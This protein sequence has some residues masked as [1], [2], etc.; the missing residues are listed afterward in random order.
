MAEY[1]EGTPEAPVLR[2]Q[3]SFAIDHWRYRNNL[4]KKVREMLAGENPISAPKSAQYKV[5]VMHTFHMLAI[6]NE[7]MSRFLERPRI[8]CVSSGVSQRSRDHAT[9][10]ENWINEAWTQADMNAGTSVWNAVLR[11]ALAFDLGVERIEAA[12]AAFWPELAIKVNEDGE[13]Y[14]ELSR[15]FEDP[16]VFETEKDKYLRHCGLPIR[17]VYVPVDTY[18]PLYN[19]PTPEQEF[20]V[21]YRPLR[22]VLT[23]KMFSAE[24]KARLGE[25]GSG[26]HGLTTQVCILHVVNATTHSYF[27]LIPSRNWSGN[28]W[29]KANTPDLNQLGEP[30]LLHS[31]ETGVNRSIYNTVAGRFGGW[32]SSQDWI[33]GAW[34]EAMCALN[35][36]A[37][38]LLSQAATYLRNTS[39]PTMVTYFDPE[40]RTTDGGPPKPMTVQEGQGIAL[41]KGENM[42]ILFKPQGN[43]MFESVYDKTFQRMS[44][45]A[46]SA[47][48]MGGKLPG[49]DTGYHHELQISQSEHL[50]AKIEENFAT[51]AVNDAMLFLSHV[52]AIGEKVY[53]KPMKKDARGRYYGDAISLSA[54]DLDPM[55][56]LVAKV[57]GVSPLSTVANLRA[58]LEAT[59]P[60]P[61]GLGPL[62]DDQTA[63]E[64]FLGEEAP[65]EILAKRDIQRERN[66]LIQ[67]GVLSKMIGQKLNMMMVE[68]GVPSVSPEMAAGADP[69]LLQS[70]QGMNADGT[71]EQ[72]GGVDPRLLS[73]QLEGRDMAGMPPATEQVVTPRNGLGGGV[74]AGQPQPEQILGKRIASMMR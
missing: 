59:A 10:Q 38:E 15:K 53:V 57:R 31:Y 60:R 58:V 8:A 35:Q 70:L 55:P 24:A 61:E 56:T 9:K 43:P 22:A 68:D 41:W 16:D 40:Y 63:M 34:I 14:S 45:L 1:Y 21:E 33:E 12:P 13:E 2:E 29:P 49:V 25:A 73:A 46:G 4:I 26:K 32:R 66:G 62:Y 3:L 44:D 54:K 11:D 67:S 42:E 37:D 18:L 51:G 64:K 52:K 69:A 39:W 17:R 23:N 6:I 65:D 30:V 71:T 7:K 72:M 74:P 27:A 50:D 48:V 5:Q 28:S 36:D 20:Q 47:A 19:G